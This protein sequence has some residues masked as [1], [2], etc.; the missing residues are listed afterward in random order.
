MKK[1]NRNE[2]YHKLKGDKPFNLYA[3]RKKYSIINDD[4]RTMASISKLILPKNKISGRYS[5]K[6]IVLEKNKGISESIVFNHFSDP[7]FEHYYFYEVNDEEY[8]DILQSMKE[9][10]VIEAL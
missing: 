1:L 2:M 8:K 4:A 3:V 5:M 9:K 10:G 6:R 7:N